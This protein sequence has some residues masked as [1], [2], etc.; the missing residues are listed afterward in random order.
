MSDGSSKNSTQREKKTHSIKSEAPE[1][2]QNAQLL[3]LEKTFPNVNTIFLS[4]KVGSLQGSKTI[5]SLDTSV[6]LLPYA[7]R[8]D[9]LQGIKDVYTTLK[10]ENR[11]LLPTRVAREFI[12]NRDRCLGEIASAINDLRSRIKIGDANLSPIFRGVMGSDQL[13]KASN[14][15]A[16]AKETYSDAL[17]KIEAQLLSWRGDD[18]LT[19][20]YALCFEKDNLIDIDL[21]ETTLSQE[22]LSRKLF[23]IPPGYKDSGKDDGGVGDLIIWKTLLQIGA[24]KKCDMCFVTAD[25]KSDWFVN[26]SNRPLYPRP[27]LIDEYRR[28]SDGHNIKIISLHELLSEMSAPTQLVEEVA[29]AER[30]VTSSHL[31][32]SVIKPPYEISKINTPREVKLVLPYGGGSPVEFE[33]DGKIFYLQLDGSI[34]AGFGGRQPMTG[35]RAQVATL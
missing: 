9:D 3:A 34:N 13:V 28:H 29:N 20:F 6:L 33:A 16:K 31:E 4:N 1:N 7:I 15:F 18:P 25:S 2:A 27:E 19:S 12:R 35:A 22:I 24:L 32:S 21:D 30:A 14:D 8:N 5:V 10:R 11:L 23:K 26:S 17:S